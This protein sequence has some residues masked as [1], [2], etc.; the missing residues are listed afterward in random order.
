LFGSNDCSQCRRLDENAGLYL[1]LDFSHPVATFDG[2][3]DSD[4]RKKD[5]K[6][7]D[8]DQLDLETRQ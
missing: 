8:R 6:N 1:I 3:S 2:H 7:E 4:R 5:R